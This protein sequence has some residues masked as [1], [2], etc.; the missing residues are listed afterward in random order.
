VVASLIRLQLD[1][2]TVVST[3][4]TAASTVAATAA[5]AAAI[6]CR[7]SPSPNHSPALSDF[8][9]PQLL[10]FTIDP[11]KKQP[12]NQAKTIFSEYCAAENGSVP[13]WR[14]RTNNT[15]MF[16]AP[17]ILSTV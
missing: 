13:R 2:V 14:G 1:N 6:P 8:S 3:A 7:F 4:A 11:A 16:S 5:A 10:I 12:K 17:C 15:E 9:K